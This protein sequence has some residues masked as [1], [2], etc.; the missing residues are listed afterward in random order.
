MPLKIAITEGAEQADIVKLARGA[1]PA[2]TRAETTRDKERSDL[3]AFFFTTVVTSHTCPTKHHPRRLRGYKAPT[4]KKPRHG[5]TCN[6]TEGTYLE[7]P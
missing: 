5:I 1:K 4:S 3:H 7:L 6:K 2:G